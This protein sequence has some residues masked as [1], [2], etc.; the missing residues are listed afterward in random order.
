MG[1]RASLTPDVSEVHA[2]CGLASYC[3]EFL[4]G[5]EVPF[6]W[7]AGCG[8]AILELRQRLTSAPILVAPHNGARASLTLVRRGRHRRSESFFEKSSENVAGCQPFLQDLHTGP[9]CFSSIFVSSSNV[10]A[11]KMAE[12]GRKSSDEALGHSSPVTVV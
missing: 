8:V 11:S 4:S 5:M 3:A 7:D 12:G 10:L 9:Y 6:G 2:F 1:A